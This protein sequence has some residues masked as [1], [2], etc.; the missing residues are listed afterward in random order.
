ML[1]ANLSPEIAATLG[2]H[3]GSGEGVEHAVIALDQPMTIAVEQLERAQLQHALRVC[4]GHAG[5]AAA[6]LGLSRKW[7]YLKQRRYRDR[8]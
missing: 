7:F 5:K 4:D 3:E 8:R 6:F 2:P 1:S